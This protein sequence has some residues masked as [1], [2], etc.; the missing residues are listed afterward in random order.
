MSKNTH[1]IYV[2]ETDSS[3][4]F[5]H[6]RRENKVFDSQNKVYSIQLGRGLDF[7]LNL[8]YC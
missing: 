6:G 7:P 4:G 8:V 3:S 5:H 2:L 1:S